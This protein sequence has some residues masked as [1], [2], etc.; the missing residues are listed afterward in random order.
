MDAHQAA[1]NP[2]VQSDGQI[3]SLSPHRVDATEYSKTARDYL[4]HLSR[5]YSRVLLV[6]CPTMH[7]WHSY[8][9]FLHF[10][11]LL[12]QYSYQRAEN[13]FDDAET[14]D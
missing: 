5:R 3:A 10:L 7:R 1:G 14:G 8:R 2:Q 13:N 12:L 11:V 6:S 4:G 9:D